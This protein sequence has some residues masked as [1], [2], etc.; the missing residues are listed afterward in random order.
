MS[1]LS[2]ILNKIDEITTEKQNEQIKLLENKRTILISHCNQIIEKINIIDLK[3]ISIIILN[4]LKNILLKINKY[5]I[6]IFHVNINYL[7]EYEKYILI[8]NKIV[9][10]LLKIVDKYDDKILIISD[11]VHMIKINN[12]DINVDILLDIFNTIGD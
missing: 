4:L 1:K 5:T 9:D 11:C 2:K 7:C 6:D 12:P 8:Y 10:T 3:S